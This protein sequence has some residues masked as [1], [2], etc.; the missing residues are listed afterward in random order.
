MKSKSDEIEFSMA[1][2][3]RINRQKNL[4]LSP[5]CQLSDKN[6]TVTDL[7]KYR[8]SNDPFTHNKNSDNIRFY[9]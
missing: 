9:H 7:E 3:Y 1:F 2:Y 6:A 8:T 4:W 5:L